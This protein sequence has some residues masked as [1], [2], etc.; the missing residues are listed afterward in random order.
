MAT[1]IRVPMGIG[2]A[3]TKKTNKKGIKRRGKD[4]L[5]VRKGNQDEYRAESR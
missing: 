4:V 1:A 2:Y 3:K 5:K